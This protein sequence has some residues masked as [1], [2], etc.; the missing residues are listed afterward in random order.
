[1]ESTSVSQLISS[2]VY[3]LV[4]ENVAF[5]K[6]IE[7]DGII[8]V[9]PG[10]QSQDIV[11]KMHQ[12][13]VKPKQSV[14]TSFKDSILVEK[15][16]EPGPVIINKVG[17]HTFDV[18]KVKPAIAKSVKRKKRPKY[19]LSLGRKKGRYRTIKSMEQV[20]DDSVMDN[21][22]R[23]GDGTDGIDTLYNGIKIKEEIESEPEIHREYDMTNTSCSINED[24]TENDI[25]N[26]DN[27]D[28]TGEI[29]DST[30]I[31][32]EHENP[33]EDETK[34]VMFANVIK[35]EQEIT[36]TDDKQ[37]TLDT[38]D[39]QDDGDANA[40]DEDV[41]DAN[42]DD[43]NDDIANDSDGED[44]DWLIEG[45]QHKVASSSKTDGHPAPN[46]IVKGPA[47]TSTT[48]QD[49]KDIANGSLHMKNTKQALF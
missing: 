20:D 12:V 34:S 45:N 41:G 7:I 47:I 3:N 6:C 30:I 24:N 8:C 36:I 32:N 40:D 2:A 5:S 42:A 18:T 37:I 15:N 38:C 39:E 46:L 33:L 17:E 11:I 23:H 4:T 10:D 28:I 27:M 19:R 22:C 16:M 43:D 21:A 44:E 1:M 14:K 25:T 13:F 35:T 9:S 31:Q 48:T 29:S 49:K 26:Y